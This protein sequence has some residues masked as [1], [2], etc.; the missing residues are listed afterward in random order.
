[1]QCP[2]CGKEISQAD[3]Y[4]ELEEEA[5]VTLANLAQLEIEARDVIERLLQRES[6]ISRLQTKISLGYPN[7]WSKN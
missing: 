2:H 6:F 1:M 4:A 7:S 3:I 5:E